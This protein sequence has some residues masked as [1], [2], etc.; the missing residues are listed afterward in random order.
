MPSGFDSFASGL[1]EGAGAPIDGTAQLFGAE[2]AMARAR[3]DESNTERLL[4]TAGQFVG[5]AGVF[6]AATIGARL[7]LPGAGRYAPV[8]AGATLGFLA[9]S[10]NNSILGR[11]EH[12][13][14]GGGAAWALDGAAGAARRGRVGAAPTPA[15]GEYQQYFKDL[16]G[17]QPVG[18]ARFGT[19]LNVAAGSELATT[20]EM[21]QG[22]VGRAEVLAKDPV[23]GIVGRHGTVFGVTTDG[24]LMTVNHVTENALD[25][26]VF[27]SAERAHRARVIGANPARDL[28]VLQLQDASSFSAFKPVK[29][30]GSLD[31]ANDGVF[32]AFGHPNGWRE[33]HVAPGRLA[34]RQFQAGVTT[35]YNMSAQEGFSGSPIVRDGQ[36]ESV[37]R[38]GIGQ[39]EV[40]GTPAHHAQELLDNAVATE[41]GA[42]ASGAKPKF[43]FQLIKSFRIHD[44]AAASENLSKMFG[45]ALTGERPAEFFHS[46]VRTVPL[47]GTES[48]AVTMQMQY[49]PAE[50]QVVIRPIAFD[51]KPIAG[52]AVWPRTSMKAGQSRLVVALDENGLPKHMTS[53]ND[54]GNIL[55]EGFNYRGENNYLAT[56]QQRPTPVWQRML[57]AAL[58]FKVG[59]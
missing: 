1:R 10:E 3:E 29:L 7:L 34:P 44:Q 23:E 48:G 47:P 38:Q 35:R 46:R 9:P 11:A 8:I 17:L 30:A 27:D 51:G 19:K 31:A 40:L 52:D 57:P 25:V 24:K 26:T 5:G 32:A 4:H 42:A 36:V 2:L 21:M 56:L 15:L 39:T 33:L 13:L 22:T 41:S 59:T 55:Q 43:D 12:A 20:Y 58:R 16:P 6:T 50:G 18:P 37:Y 45:G 49:L 28:A 14:M 53:Y 54:P